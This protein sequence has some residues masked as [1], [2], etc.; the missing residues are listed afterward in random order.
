MPLYSI[1][2][3]HKKIGSSN[4]LVPLVGLMRTLRSVKVAE[5]HQMQPEYFLFP[6]NLGTFRTR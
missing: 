4:S 2:K 6:G 5:R 3:T 1:P